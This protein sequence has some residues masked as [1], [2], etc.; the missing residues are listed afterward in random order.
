MI[1]RLQTVIFLIESRA[2]KAC[3]VWQMRVVIQ[4]YVLRDKEGET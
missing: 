4:R 3:Q 2:T 1:G